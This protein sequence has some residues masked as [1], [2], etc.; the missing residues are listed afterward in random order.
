MCK[1]VIFQVAYDMD[2]FNH[3]FSIFVYVSSCM[4]FYID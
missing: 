1:N 4:F 2:K 3:V